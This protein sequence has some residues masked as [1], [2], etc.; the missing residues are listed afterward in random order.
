MFWFKKCGFEIK[1]DVKQLQIHLNEW[2]AFYN[3]KRKHK[4]LNYKTPFETLNKFYCCYLVILL[5]IF[6]NNFIRLKTYYS[7]RMSSV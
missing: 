1:F 3:F 5:L 7:L 6:H 2:Y 4:S